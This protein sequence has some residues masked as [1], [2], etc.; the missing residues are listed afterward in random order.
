MKADPM[1][2]DDEGL[3]R[4]RPDPTN[5]PEGIDVA[6]AVRRVRPLDLNHLRSLEAGL[7]EWASARG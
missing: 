5:H 4:F 6:A 1:E 2:L 3:P 7:Q